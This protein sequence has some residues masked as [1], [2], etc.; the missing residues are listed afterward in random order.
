MTQPTA[1]PCETYGYYVL[2][3]PAEYRRLRR[4]ET[5]ARALIAYHA[6]VGVCIFQPERAEMFVRLLQI[7][8]QEVRH[9]ETTGA[10]STP[11][12]NSAESRDD[13]PKDHGFPNEVQ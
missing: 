6:G 8:I 2:L 3:P 10:V 4:I 5:A 9:H 7:A 12:Q 13:C 1:D 11:G